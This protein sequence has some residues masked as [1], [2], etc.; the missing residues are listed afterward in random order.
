MHCLSSSWPQPPGV[1]QGPQWTG[2]EFEGGGGEGGQKTT[3]Q[4]E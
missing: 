2:E 4:F 1:V 3:R